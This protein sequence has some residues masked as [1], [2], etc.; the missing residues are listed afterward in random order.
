MAA[1]VWFDLALLYLDEGARD[2]LSKLSNK[3]L[4]AL[5][6]PEIGRPELVQLLHF[7]DAC[8]KGELTAELIESLAHQLERSRRPSLAWWSAW[9][10]VLIPPGTSHD[11]SLATG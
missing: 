5:D 11:A 3:P 2:S 1:L 8:T 4:G 9:G 7:L 6:S 10:T